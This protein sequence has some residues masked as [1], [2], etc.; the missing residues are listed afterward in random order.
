MHRISK[1]LNAPTLLAL[2]AV[3]I[4][5]GGPADAASLITGSQVKNSS[6]SGSDVR[7]NSLTGIDIKNLRKGDFAPGQLPAGAKG[8]A[9]PKGDKGDAGPEGPSRWVLVNRAGII[10]AQSGGFRIANAYPRNSAGEGN[11]YIDSGDTDLSDN[12]IVATI[13]L[14]NQYD[15]DTLDAIR[16]G[17][18][19]GADANPEFS[20]EITASKCAIASIVAC[21]P[22]DLVANGGSGATTNTNRHFV[23]SPRNSDGSFTTNDD[24]ATAGVN[25]DSHKRFYVVLSGPRTTP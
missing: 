2:A 11:V 14:E 21:A 17:R 13:A 25:E 7:N 4:A 9:G 1:L 22:L 10:E 23:V 18:A 6:L 3:F 8:D 19:P 5:V 15:L 16:N 20:G 12:G 24:L